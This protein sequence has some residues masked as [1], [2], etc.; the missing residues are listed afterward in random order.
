M[1]TIHRHIHMAGQSDEV[2]RG[3]PIRERRGLTERQAEA[4]TVICEFIRR[5]NVSPTTRQ[6]GAELGVNSTATV[7]WL[8][9]ELAERGWID[10]APSKARSIMPR[11]WPDGRPFVDAAEGTVRDLIEAYEYGITAAKLGQPLNTGRFHGKTG[12]AFALG[13]NAAMLGRSGNEGVFL[14][15]AGAPK[16]T[17][18]T[19]LENL[20]KAKP[21]D[22][23]GDS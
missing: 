16:T 7:N 13:W 22:S 2:A 5:R 1:H 3:A 4:L 8:V 21:P 11:A 19:T 10:R 9:R 14:D 23:H 17:P 20:P 15:G 18:G 12:E 6:I